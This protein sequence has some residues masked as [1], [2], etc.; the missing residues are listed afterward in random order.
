M[1]EADDEELIEQIS[2]LN[3][4]E[5]NG[6]T[7]TVCYDEKND[8]CKCNMNACQSYICSGCLLEYL[9]VCYDNN[10]LPMC[11]MQGGCKGSYDETSLSNQLII[12]KHEYRRFL[13]KWYVEN[14][15]D[16][17]SFTIDVEKARAE[18]IKNKT[19][20]INERM[21]RAIKACADIIFRKEMKSGD[22]AIKRELDRRRQK[23]K[24]MIKKL[25]TEEDR[26]ISNSCI[27]P[28]CKG[29][30]VDNKCNV[31]G[32]VRCDQCKEVK[33]NDHVCNPDIL[34][35]IK[36]ISGECCA[37][38]K[39]NAMINR[40]YGCSDMQC[41]YC[42]QYFTYNPGGIGTA[43]E[44]NSNYHYNAK[45][46]DFSTYEKGSLIRELNL[47]GDM[48]T[49]IVSTI[50]RL[51]DELDIDQLKITTIYSEK[52]AKYADRLREFTPTN[53]VETELYDTNLQVFSEEYASLLRRHLHAIYIADRLNE[54][55]AKII[56]GIL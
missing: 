17:L 29:I 13:L 26:P 2:K 24:E 55:I 30:I 39:C 53:D 3:I 56:T 15:K 7:C 14:S 25:T 5:S 52:L 38:P 49:D 36:S 32:L 12:V 41:T 11:I 1:A 20:F 45:K 28:L 54:I 40:S 27:N 22:A 8:I 23:S 18:I 50:S 31:C 16:I 10:H 33:L 51:E 44:R 9:K 34:E 21:P 46:R 6:K 47:V 43:N 4:L 35:S 42:G 37:C 48:H 19:Q